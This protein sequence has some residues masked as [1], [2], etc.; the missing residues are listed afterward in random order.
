[1]S[2]LDLVVT[3]LAAYRLTQLVSSDRIARPL[4]HLPGMLGELFSCA[5]CISVWIGGAVV[6]LWTLAP[7]Y[8]LV[9]LAPFAVSAVAIV[10][11][12]VVAAITRTGTTQ[13][14]TVLGQ[15]SLAPE[16][17]Q[18]LSRHEFH[19]R[20]LALCLDELLRKNGGLAGL[21]PDEERAIVGR[22]TADMARR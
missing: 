16:I 15:A 1:M 11:M 22:I 14:A 21:T 17:E 4:R 8:A 20:R 19:L 10:A 5:L 6:A 3:G 13:Q 2:P 12:A 18:T 7:R 9:M